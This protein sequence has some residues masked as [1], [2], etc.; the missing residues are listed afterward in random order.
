MV[1][2]KQVGEVFHRILTVITLTMFLLGALAIY[3][4]NASPFNSYGLIT[5][6]A[7][8]GLVVGVTY[9]VI[10]IIATYLIHGYVFNKPDEK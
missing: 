5:G 10:V 2:K 7:I 1:S 3:A 6:L 4:M 8:W 9:F